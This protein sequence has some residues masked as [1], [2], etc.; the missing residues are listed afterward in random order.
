MFKKWRI[1]GSKKVICYG[2]FELFFCSANPI[3]YTKNPMTPPIFFLDYHFRTHKQSKSPFNRCLSIEKKI[4]DQVLL[5]LI[6]RRDSIFRHFVWILEIT[7]TRCKRSFINTWPKSWQQLNYDLFYE[8]I[9]SESELIRSYRNG[10][11]GLY[12]SINLDT[13]N[14]MS[15]L[16]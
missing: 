10:R 15:A 6:I 13:I 4:P 5:W 7:S 2:L 9:V 12:L 11:R 3:S 1:S 16:I 8:F 14:T